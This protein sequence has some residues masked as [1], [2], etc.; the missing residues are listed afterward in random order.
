[1]HLTPDLVACYQGCQFEITLRTYW[2][3]LS[4][5]G[6]INSI[7]LKDGKVR[8]AASVVAQRD[9]SR[10]KKP[11]F[12]RPDKQAFDTVVDPRLYVLKKT[13][14][15]KLVFRSRLCEETLTLFPAGYINFD[16]AKVK[17]L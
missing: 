7:S 15:G 6:N 2:F 4:V 1:M 16:P 10:G 5:F 3:K 13:I 9:A 8:I 14:D 11:T 12:A 17:S